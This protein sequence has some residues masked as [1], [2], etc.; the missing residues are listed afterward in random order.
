M[1]EI[2]SEW[3]RLREHI[4]TMAESGTNDYVCTPS[5][6]LQLEQV[7]LRAVAAGLRKYAIAG[8]ALRAGYRP[9]RGVAQG[10]PFFTAARLE[11]RAGALTGAAILLQVIWRTRSG[12]SGWRS[13]YEPAII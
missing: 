9:A 4:R 7:R 11:R 10:A 2:A 6:S 5:G 13:L 1:T 12:G 8:S 3:K